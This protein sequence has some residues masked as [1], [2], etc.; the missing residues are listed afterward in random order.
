MTMRLA[1][2]LRGLLEAHVE[3]VVVGGLAANVHGSARITADVDI[4]YDPA[5]ENRARLARLLHDWHA[6]LRGVEP[7]L[8][9]T[10]DARTLRDCPVMTLVTDL[11]DIDVMDR[12]AG[13]GEYPAVRAASVE[14]DLGGVRAN[15]LA[16][17]ALIAAKRA[18]GRRKDRE[19]LLE[20]EA[21]REERRRR[22]M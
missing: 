17:D 10:M 2:I 3:C 1:E 20:L 21:L 22:G 5:P 16:L 7:G 12:V 6:Y 13:V 19:A 11:G 15:V 14:A 8:P 18:A 9:F 4:C